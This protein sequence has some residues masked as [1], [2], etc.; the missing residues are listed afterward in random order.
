MEDKSKKDSGAF[1]KKDFIGYQEGELTKYYEIGKSLGKGGFGSVVE[2]R[3]RA[4][5][6]IRACKI[7]PKKNIKNKIKFDKE[8]EILSTSDS[9]YIVRLFE[10][11][12]DSKNF[13]VVMDKCEGGTLDNFVMNRIQD[14]SKKDGEYGEEVVKFI[15][16]Q[17]MEAVSYCHSKNL[18]HRD[19]KLENIMLLTNKIENGIKVI[20]F[21]LAQYS[22]SNNL[23]EFCGTPNYIAP[24]VIQGKYDQK[25]DIWS[26]GIILY[27]LIC[28]EFPF[29]EANEE[30]LYKKIVKMKFT[31]KGNSWNKV[32]K[33][34][35]DLVSKM[36]CHTSGRLTAKQV[37]DHPWLKEKS[38]TI[39]EFDLDGL[40]KYINKGLLYKM[41]RTSLVSRFDDKSAKEIKE[42]FS[43]LDKDHDGTLDFEELKTILE[44]AECKDEND[45]LM[46]IKQ[47]FDSLDTDKSGKLDYTE[48]LAAFLDDLYIKKEE[49][50]MEAFQA[51][52][53]D[54]SGKISKE[55]I[56]A[57]LGQEGIKGKELE[58]MISKADTNFDGSIDYNEFIKYLDLKK[59]E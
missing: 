43:K 44:K 52:D 14:K 35:K 9:P 46:E 56:K 15:F 8:I 45:N 27:L 3:R 4:T 32:N 22:K 6:E 11:F 24:E 42:M 37:L 25:C 20:D 41:M 57:I 38:N 36:I 59:L 1:G 5:E 39:F 21:G 53:K 2:V 26:A 16:R 31:F 54:G 10:V 12:Q 47:T 50:L 55:E 49:Y 51:M 18:C 58:D 34:A 40:Q 28:G 17:I 30:D 23:R 33:K 19:L 7:I 48:F 13:Y 29:N